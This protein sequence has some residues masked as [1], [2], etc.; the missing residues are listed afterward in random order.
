MYPDEALSPPTHMQ[1]R[2]QQQAAAT[3]PLTAPRDTPH[4]SAATIHAQTITTPTELDD[5]GL[6]DD[7]LYDEGGF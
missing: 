7:D 3:D 1:L 5:D 6:H 4:G 2:Q